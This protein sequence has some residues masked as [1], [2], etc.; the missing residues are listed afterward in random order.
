MITVKNTEWK[1]LINLANNLGW[2]IDRMSSSGGNV[3]TELMDL[4]EIINE[5]RIKNESICIGR[6][7]GY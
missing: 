2:E 7:L 4:L 5:R 1:K 3:Y 6:G